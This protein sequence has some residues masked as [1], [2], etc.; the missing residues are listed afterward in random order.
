MKRI[1]TLLLV[2]AL[3]ALILLPVSAAVNNNLN[4]DGLRADE[5]PIPPVPPPKLTMLVA[6]SEMIEASLMS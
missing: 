2:S 3:A 6:A 1:T 5:F 4:N